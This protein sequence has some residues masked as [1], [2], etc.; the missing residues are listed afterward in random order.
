M[1]PVRRTRHTQSRPASEARPSAR[2]TAPPSR[3]APQTPE[4]RPSDPSRPIGHA[5]VGR[6]DEQEHSENLC[7]LDRD[8][9]RNLHLITRENYVSGEGRPYDPESWTPSAQAYVMFDELAGTQSG[10]RNRDDRIPKRLI[11]TL[12]KW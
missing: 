2:C 7:Y 3:T 10:S 1:P 11:D 12:E 4:A 8:I 9:R 5:T 6:D